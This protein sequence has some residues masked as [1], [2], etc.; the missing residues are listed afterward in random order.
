MNLEEFEAGEV[1]VTVLV[2]VLQSS[3]TNQHYV[4]ITDDLERRIK[5]HNA[6]R[7]RATCGRGPWKLLYSETCDDYLSARKRERFFKSGPGHA[8]LKKA[9][10]A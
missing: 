2:C 1:I 9:G 3:S 5:E 7:S 8:F 10:V 6:N 4:G